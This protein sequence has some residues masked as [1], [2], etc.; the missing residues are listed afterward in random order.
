MKGY[1]SGR[2]M[3]MI[4][5]LVT[6]TIVA[7]LAAIALPAFN[8]MLTNNRAQAQAGLL[9][10]SF[11]Y[12]RSEAVRQATWIAVRPLSGTDWTQGW[13]VWVDADNDGVFDANELELQH[14]DALTG[15]PTITASTSVI[16]FL[17]SGY[18][19]DVLVMASNAFSNEST[20]L[21]TLGTGN[22]YCTKVIHAGRV[23]FQK[24]STCP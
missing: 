3:T 6:I 1:R 22:S 7:I 9:F 17:P 15:G 20:F 11:N 18:F 2:G 8:K 13:R 4:E 19:N 5:L 21:Y 23:S 10:R 12:A 16:G 14:Q 24:Q